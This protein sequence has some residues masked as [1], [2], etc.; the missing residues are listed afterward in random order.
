MFEIETIA[1]QNSESLTIESFLARIEELRRLAHANDSDSQSSYSD[2]EYKIDAEIR[3][4]NSED[5]IDH[6]PVLQS[7]RKSRELQQVQEDEQKRLLKEER[8][9]DKDFAA[10]KNLLEEGTTEASEDVQIDSSTD[11]N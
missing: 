1:T 6:G 8:K 4:H 7:L 3:R 2:D 11:N 5:E 9:K 10:A